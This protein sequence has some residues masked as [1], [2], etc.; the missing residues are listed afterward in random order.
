MVWP[1]LSLGKPSIW[2]L[3]H[4]SFFLNKKKKKKRGWCPHALLRQE[5]SNAASRSVAECCSFI[6]VNVCFSFCYCL[7]WC[8][9]LIC[10][11]KSILCTCFCLILMKLQFSWLKKIYSTF[12]CLCDGHDI[13]MVLKMFVFNCP[14]QQ[15]SLF[16]SVFS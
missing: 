14:Q 4:A 7:F 12:C 3:E 1:C 15:A 6:A 8:E 10:S 11:C 13:G 5:A 9:P 16:A 2:E